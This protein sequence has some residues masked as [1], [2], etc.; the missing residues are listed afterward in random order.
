MEAF[1]EQR[2]LE[3]FIKNLEIDRVSLKMSQQQMANYLDMSLSTY[4]R[5]I[6]GDTGVKGL[7]VLGKMY[8][9]KGKFC[10]EYVEVHDPLLDTVA[11]L[12][13]LSLEDLEL[14]NQLIDRI[15]S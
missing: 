2:F 10:F 8:Q 6:N 4:K 14:I 11:K 9:L 3:L 7:Y 5:I 13:G 12:K 1:N 15:S